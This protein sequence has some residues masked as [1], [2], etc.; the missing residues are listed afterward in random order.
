VA[1]I[2]PFAADMHTVGI[3]LV[4]AV[5]VDV[6]VHMR[7]GRMASL[8]VHTGVVVVAVDAAVGVAADSAILLPLPLHLPFLPLVHTIVVAC[9]HPSCSTINE[10]DVTNKTITAHSLH[11]DR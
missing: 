5:V 6:V 1:G 2:V 7:V 8:L 9:L 3:A 11:C 4:V 10:C